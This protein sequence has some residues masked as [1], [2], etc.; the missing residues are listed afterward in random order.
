MR[1]MSPIPFPSRHGRSR[2]AAS[3]LFMAALLV[4]AALLLS[5]TW[6]RHGRAE[7]PL[8]LPEFRHRQPTAWI[9]SP[10]L[11]RDDL[12]GQV[13]LIEIWTSV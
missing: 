8:T 4:T 7:A 2:R 11:S 12:R 6:P 3:P 5:S 10:P 1:R 9:N 13:V